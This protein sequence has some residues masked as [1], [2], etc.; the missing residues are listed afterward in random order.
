MLDRARID[1]KPEAPNHGLHYPDGSRLLYQDRVATGWKVYVV[2]LDQDG[3]EPEPVLDDELAWPRFS[4]DGRFFAYSS[5]RTGST[6]VH[7][8]EFA[9][10]RPTTVSRQGGSAPFWARDGSELY[11]HHGGALM[12]AAVTATEPAFDVAAPQPLF[13][14][15][16]GFIEDVAADGRFLATKRLPTDDEG[17][18]SL[19]IRVVL[20]WFEELKE[21]VPIGR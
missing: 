12:V 13:E 19:Q 20:N 6:Q 21:R 14:K 18:A 10:G 3:A 16:G 9:T 4:P 1:H 11:F 2:A 5:R 17:A 8:Y 7:V 15:K